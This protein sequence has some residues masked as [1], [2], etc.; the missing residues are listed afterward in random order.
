M[1]EGR[2]SFC[3]LWCLMCWLVMVCP[4]FA[5]GVASEQDIKPITWPSHLAAKREHSKTIT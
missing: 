1:P 2:S 4:R 3:S 5:K